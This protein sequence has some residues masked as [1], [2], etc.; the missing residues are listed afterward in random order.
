MS[1]KVVD[2]QLLWDFCKDLV[3]NGAGYVWGGRGKKY[4]I[5]EAQYLLET[6]GNSTYNSTYYMTTQMKRFGGKIVIDCSGLIEAF[7]KKYLDGKDSTAHGLYEQCGE[8]VG[9]LDTLPTNKRGV[10]LFKKSG[11]RMG[12]VGVYGG[13]NT[14]I[15]AMNSTRGVVETN[16][17]Y[18]PNWT[19]W[20][21]HPLIPPVTVYEEEELDDE[22]EIEVNSNGVPHRVTNCWK[23]NVRNSASAK[24]KSV[25]II[26]RD[27]I[28]H[29]YET[30]DGWCRI[31]PKKQMWCSKKYLKALP[32]MMVV[33]CGA[34]YVRNQPN[35]GGKA[36]RTLK[37]GAY[38]YKYGTA[39]TGWIKISPDKEEYS[40]FKYLN[41]IK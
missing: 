40:S 1:K 27:D 19:H 41:E 38:V 4:D 9:T 10:L 24:G 36:L 14:T 26:S 5:A 34:L 8:N 7:R 33:N 6:Y 13:D 11:S 28:I 23:L 21:I 20:G 17:I 37:K 35:A 3:A 16:P 32:K 39:S 2:G 22:D 25:K 30:K 12:H 31:D 15:E 18:K 29:V